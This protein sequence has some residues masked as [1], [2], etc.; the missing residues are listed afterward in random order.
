MQI[1]GI[2]GKA[3]SNSNGCMDLTISSR[4]NPNFS[5][6]TE[7]HVL[8]KITGTQPS[9]AVATKESTHLS[10]LRL[11]DPEFR[12]PKQIDVLLAADVTMQ[13]FTGS[14]PIL[15]EREVPIA[16][17]THFGHVIKGRAL[18]KPTCYT[19]L[20]TSEPSIS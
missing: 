15:G 9:H 5:M 4:L 2:G 3:T 7:A 18:T 20:A 19:H 1:Y 8:P 13:S 14:P 17:A 11:A 10:N 6:E 16:L 12:L